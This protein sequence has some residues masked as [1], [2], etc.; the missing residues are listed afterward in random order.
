M[1]PLVSS[2][3]IFWAVLALFFLATL[4]TVHSA[5]WHI[6]YA[7]DKFAIEIYSGGY[8]HAESTPYSYYTNNWHYFDYPYR[9]VY[10]GTYYYYEPGWYR[11]NS[12]WAYNPGNTSYYD[13]YPADYYYNDSYWAYSPGWPQKYGTYY[14][15]N[16]YYPCRFCSSGTGYSY[17]PFN[18]AKCSELKITGNDVYLNAGE[19]KET[20]FTIKNTSAM[21]FKFTE[22]YTSIFDS[23]VEKENI[24]HPKKIKSGDS[25]TISVQLKAD[26]DAKD[27]TI[28]ASISINGQFAD[29][30]VCR[31]KEKEFEIKVNGENNA[32]LQTPNNNQGKLGYATSTSYYSANKDYAPSTWHEI[33]SPAEPTGEAVR[34]T[35]VSTGDW[36]QPTR[37]IIAQEQMAA[38]ETVEQIEFSAYKETE[39]TMP[40][41]KKYPAE[42]LAK[43]D[44]L[45]K[46][47]IPGKIILNEE[48]VFSVSLDNPGS[49]NT[50]VYIKTQNIT[51]ST[52]AISV[53][54][55][56][57]AERTIKISGFTAEKGYIFYSIY[58]DGVKIKEMVTYLEKP[59]K[60]ETPVA[61][62]GSEKRITVTSYSEEIELNN[63]DGNAY[64]KIRNT[65]GE[66]Q[67]YEITLE[68][69]NDFEAT[70]KEF[71][72]TAGEEKE[73]TMKINA[74]DANT[75]VE[76]YA[77]L[78]VKSGSEEVFKKIK[79]VPRAITNAAEGKSNG[80][81]AERDKG[82]TAAISNI[83]MAVLGNAGNIGI[84]LA[85]MLLA[86][87]IYK[88]ASLLKKNS[89]YE[90]GN[91][92]ASYGS[93]EE[94]DWLL[95]QQATA[96]RNRA[97]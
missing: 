71:S 7:N 58:Y 69:N 50:T 39:V 30:T 84:S 82:I 94:Q 96:L 14:Y 35:P 3:G 64:I 53:D 33:N 22:V 48:T 5:Y 37:G 87:M 95:E 43:E 67:V 79:I 52:N 4:G 44:P 91:E 83:G 61:S 90:A 13:Y 2:K 42:H 24:D 46:L 41:A 40:L 56:S 78:K 11:Y 19:S 26:S 59:K 60:Q 86:V 93:E 75:A 55:K 32:A 74:L 73:T 8:W 27:K 49:K 68:G 76:S 88:A 65:S 1:A 29:G 17:N 89:T 63:K 9:V 15:G 16:Y 80:A 12:Y 20:E 45:P 38:Q 66:K 54:K 70:A 28:S 34:S 51:A 31:K 85:I 18:K 21:D 81:A 72:L 36:A 47:A 23:S 10:S 6:G 62:T 25:K 77:Y 92:W 97:I 57:Y